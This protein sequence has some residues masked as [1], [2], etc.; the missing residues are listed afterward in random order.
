M[1]ILCSQ[2]S[3]AWNFKIV[4]SPGWVSGEVPLADLQMTTFCSHMAFLLCAAERSSL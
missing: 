3:G 4:M 2:C 1:E